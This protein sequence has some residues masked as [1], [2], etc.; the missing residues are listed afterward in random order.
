MLNVSLNKNIPTYI[1]FGGGGGGLLKILFLC[2]FYKGRAIFGI[3]QMFICKFQKGLMI[4]YS[5][6]KILFLD[7]N[8][9]KKQFYQETALQ[10]NTERRLS[11]PCLIGIY[12]QNK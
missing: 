3:C 4:L 10:G 11:S 2:L 7:Y 12:A 5:S 8:N 1:K 9:K 6:G